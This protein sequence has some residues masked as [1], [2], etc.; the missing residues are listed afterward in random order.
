MQPR[1]LFGGTENHNVWCK[2]LKLQLLVPTMQ[3]WFSVT[4]FYCLTDFVLI[5]MPFVFESVVGNSKTTGVCYNAMLPWVKFI[6]IFTY[7]SVDIVLK[8]SVML[9]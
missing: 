4:H 9:D 8:C 7:N 5:Y 1:A 6:L 3:S 2:T